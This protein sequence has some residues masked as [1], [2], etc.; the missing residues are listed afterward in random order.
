MQLSHLG[1]AQPQSAYRSGGRSPVLLIPGV[2]ETWHFLRPLADRLNA[3]GH[4][5]HILRELGYNRLSIAASAGLAET[6]LRQHGLSE[7]VIIG[8][9]K[10]GLIAKQL[11]V[12]LLDA[13]DEESLRMV[14]QLI[15]VNSPFGG[16]SLARWAPTPTLRAFAPRNSTV[17]TLAANLVVNS[18]I[19]SI[20]SRLDPLIPSGSAL[21]GAHNVELPLVG[22]FRPLASR[23]LFDVVLTAVNADHE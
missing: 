9:S 21:A 12:S 23:A 17:L 6:Y 10:G 7:V 8:H 2:Y 15:T 1:S 5:I 19:T 16:S 4:P 22:H 14:A 20:Y 13:A 18:R 11:M 3:Q